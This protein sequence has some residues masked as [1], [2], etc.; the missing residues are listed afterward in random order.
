MMVFE[1]CRRCSCENIHFGFYGAN[2]RG[3]LRWTG[4]RDN[5]SRRVARSAG[6]TNLFNKD[7]GATG[8]LYLGGYTYPGLGG[9]VG[10]TDWEYATPRTVYLQISRAFGP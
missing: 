5:G 9:T 3:A 10:P 2:N 7:N 6:A 8:G 4:S 1:L